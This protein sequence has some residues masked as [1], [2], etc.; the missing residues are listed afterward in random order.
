V[1]SPLGEI[2][3]RISRDSNYK[4]LPSDI[5]KNRHTPDFRWLFRR[6]FLEIKEEAEQQKRMDEMG[7]D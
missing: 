5:L 3:F 7:E 1:E 2:T 6:Y 4:Y